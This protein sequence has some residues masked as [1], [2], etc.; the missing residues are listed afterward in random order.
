MPP[1]ARNLCLAVVAVF[2]AAYASANPITLTV[3][4][5]AQPGQTFHGNGA[6]AYGNA[7]TN[8]LMP[9]SRGSKQK[10]LFNVAILGMTQPTL[11]SP[12]LLSLATVDYKLLSYCASNCLLTIDLAAT[13]FTQPYNSFQTTLGGFMLQGSTKAHYT[14]TAFLNPFSGSPSLLGSCSGTSGSV[15]ACSNRSPFTYT[16][17]YGL[18]LK[19]VLDANS[20]SGTFTDSD[21]SGVVP[22]PGTLALFGVAMVGFAGT[23]RRRFSM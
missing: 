21:I 20:G 3:S 19:L 6:V 18:E 16:G 1:V 9:V 2:F 17:T 4:Q 10:P 12:D 7:S 15:A 11:Q 13:G 8:T 23:M 22:E 14:L 5:N